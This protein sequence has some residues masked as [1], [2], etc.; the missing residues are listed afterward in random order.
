MQTLL[1]CYY[2]ESDFDWTSHLSMVELCYNRYVNEAT[3]HSSFED[4]Y[5]F[6]PSTIAYRLLSL[7][8]AIAETTDIMTM[9]GDIID[10]VYELIKLSKERMAA[11]STRI[12]P[13][14]QSRNHVNLS[15]NALHIRSH[16]CKHLRD[17]RLVPFV[18][19]YKVEINSYK[20]LL[21]KG[22]RLHHVFH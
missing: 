16:K 10:V 9:I 8:G 13:L 3:S 7:I 18:V 15:T 17:Q 22:C 19:I 14:F 2:A 5:G 6:Q 4:M 20:L 1:R 12:V 11:R 21:P